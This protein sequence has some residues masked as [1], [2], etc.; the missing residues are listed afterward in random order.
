MYP[1]RYIEMTRMDTSVP[2]P[3]VASILLK[4][5]D[6]ADD[7]KVELSTAINIID[8]KTNVPPTVA[9]TEMYHF[10]PSLQVFGSNGS[11]TSNAIGPVS[12]SLFI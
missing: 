11:S 5:P 9:A 4:A 10:F 8:R 3:R 6:G 7:A 1:T 2:D 12:Q